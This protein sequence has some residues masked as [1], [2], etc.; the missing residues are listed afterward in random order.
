MHTKRVEPFLDAHF[1]PEEIHHDTTSSG[2]I[3][4]EIMGNQG[5]TQR[6]MQEQLRSMYTADRVCTVYKYSMRA[7]NV[8]LLVPFA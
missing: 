2:P 7:D 8:V 3:K 4:N 6:W 5:A 1:W